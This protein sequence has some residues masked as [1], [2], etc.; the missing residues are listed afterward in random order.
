MV[1]KLFCLIAFLYSSFRLKVSCYYDINKTQAVVFHTRPRRSEPYAENARGELQVVMRLAFGEFNSHI[2]PNVS[3]TSSPQVGNFLP[4]ILT[5]FLNSCGLAVSSQEASSQIDLDL[6]VQVIALVTLSSLTLNLIII[7]TKLA[8]GKF[9]VKFTLIQIVHLFNRSY[10][11]LIPSQHNS[12]PL[13][14]SFLRL[15]LQQV[16]HQRGLPSSKIPAAAAVLRG[17][18]GEVYKPRSVSGAGE[19]LGH[20]QQRQDIPAQMEPHH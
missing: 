3:Q 12:E 15:L 19:L 20:A 2:Y 5:D 1:L 16:L 14:C 17:G 7:M 6:S 10:S 13:L 4:Q 11:C 18:A 9:C 8:K